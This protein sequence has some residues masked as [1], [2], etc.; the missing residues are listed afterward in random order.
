MKPIF[1]GGKP[2][3]HV[4]RHICK[5]LVVYAYEIYADEIT[6]YSFLKLVIIDYHN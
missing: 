2:T 3:A 1:P 6:T 5:Q 4:H